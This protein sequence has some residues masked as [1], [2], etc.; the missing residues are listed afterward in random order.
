MTAENE[1]KPVEGQPQPVDQTGGAD[2]V[3]DLKDV[4]AQVNADA[5]QINLPEKRK[6]WLD[7]ES[8]IARRVV[9]G[10]KGLFGWNRVQQPPATNLPKGDGTFDN[11]ALPIVKPDQN[12]PQ[13]PTQKP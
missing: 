8:T 7:G 1:E 3:R 10:V 11:S 9:D 13:P 6:G 5:P 4:A 2:N 12:P